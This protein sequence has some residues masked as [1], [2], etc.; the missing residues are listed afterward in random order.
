MSSIVLT[1]FRPTI[2]LLVSKCRDKVA[3]IL[4][5][6]DVTDQKFHSLIVK[7]IEEVRLKLDA[8]SRKDLEASISFFEEG[9]VLLYEVF[10]IANARGECG[11]ETAL[12][13]CNEAIPIIEGISR[14]ELTGLDES[15]TRKLSAAKERFKDARREATRAFKNEGLKTSD[16]ILAMKY[17]VMATILET[18]DHPADAVGP[19]GVCVKELNSLP[20]VQNNFD[21]QLKTGIQAV[22]GWFSQ[23]ERREII[24]SVCHV[25]R[26]IYDVT[27]TFGGDT[28]FWI[29]PTVDIGDNRINPLYDARVTKVLLNQGMEHCCV[30]PWSFGQELE[31]P[32]G[33]AT[34]SSG[35][36]NVGERRG[37]CVKVFDRNG[38][39]VKHFTLRADDVYTELKIKDVVTAVNDNIFVLT[40]LMKPTPRY[41]SSWWIYKLT[42]TADLHHMFRLR[43]GGF[44]GKYKGLSVRDTGKVVALRSRREGVE[45]YDSNGEF[46]RSFGGEI[47]KYPKDITVANDGR[48][49][50]LDVEYDSF[51]SVFDKENYFVRIFSEHGDYLNKFKLHTNNFSVPKI[52]FHPAAGGH[53]VV[54][55]M[56]REINFVQVTIYS[57]DGEFVH[58]VK[59]QNSHSFLKIGGITLN[60]DGSIAVVG[61]SLSGG[62][63]VVL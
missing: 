4:K 40:K 48:V 60:N 36:F 30:T 2:G 34:N 1:V 55:C 29:W 33:I 46:V 24:T 39:F 7:E 22:R 59:V 19:C 8:L 32:M 13:A 35:E 5:D 45:E 11:A 50:V 25:N 14:L 18:V 28:H 57:K 54:A 37:R 6:G 20:A 31:A 56:E 63:V 42:K 38:T 41:N 10:K 51:L 53:V 26:V 52:M 21:V 17:R 3:E 15:A 27:R 12:A 43:V 16:R 44:L 23:E 62:R 49:L 9:I 47:L 58:S 61:S